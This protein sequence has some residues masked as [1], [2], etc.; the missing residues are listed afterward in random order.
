MTKRQN[1]MPQGRS[2]H[3]AATLPWYGLVSLERVLYRAPLFPLPGTD[4]A[5]PYYLLEDLYNV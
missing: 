3:A 1:A 5:G 4:E 2:L